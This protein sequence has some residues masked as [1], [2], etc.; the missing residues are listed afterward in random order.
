MKKTM[1]RM[2]AGAAVAIAVT[3]TVGGVAS[4]QTAPA[5]RPASASAS[6]VPIWLLPG[7][8]L[9]SVLDSTVGVPAAAL[10]PV[11]GLLNLANG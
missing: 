5:A 1:V 10:G 7:V 4:A 11:V 8:D 6:D 9:G 3:V 2:V